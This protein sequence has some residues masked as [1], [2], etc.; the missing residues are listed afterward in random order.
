M[1]LSSRA[2]VSCLTCVAFVACGKTRAQPR[3]APSAESC[4]AWRGTPIKDRSFERTWEADKQECYL[5]GKSDDLGS[6]DG[7]AL[8]VLETLVHEGKPIDAADRAVSLR[9]DGV[10]KAEFGTCT[11]FVADIDD[12]KIVAEGQRV[13]PIG[14]GITTALMVHLTPGEARAI[15]RAERLAF[16]LCDDPSFTPSD[17]VRKLFKELAMEMPQ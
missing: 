7:T 8:R 5:H 2:L 10:G 15:A 1:S 16:A 3:D 13:V 17:G 4:T 9:F 12:R 11:R 14:D 6:H